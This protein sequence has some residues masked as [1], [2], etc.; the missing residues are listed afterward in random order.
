MVSVYAFNLTKVCHCS[1]SQNRL[2]SDNFIAKQSCHDQHWLQHD[3]DCIEKESH[4][5]F[6]K[7]VIEGLAY[8]TVTFAPQPL[9]CGIF[10]TLLVG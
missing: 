7:K 4:T 10:K 2:I 6:N 5:S 8:L 3:S 1:L 9:L